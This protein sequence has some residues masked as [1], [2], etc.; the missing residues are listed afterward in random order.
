MVFIGPNGCMEK[1]HLDAKTDFIGLQKTRSDLKLG[2]MPQ[3][4]PGTN[5]L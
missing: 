3:N 4:Y 1:L 2:I 5:A